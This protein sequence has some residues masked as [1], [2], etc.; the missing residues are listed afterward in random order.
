ML[1]FQAI[2]DGNCLYNA[3]AVSLITA[4]MQKKLNPLF[5]NKQRLAQ[6]HSLLKIF[7]N[8]GLIEVANNVTQ[9]SVTEG[10]NRLIERF[11]VGDEIDWADLQEQM[12]VGLREY[13]QDVMIND[14][15]MK[16]ALRAELTRSLNQYVDMAYNGEAGAMGEVLDLTAVVG[17]N[18]EG[19]TVI[20]EKI[21]EILQ[22][23]E[24]EG[25]DAKKAALNE[26]FFEGDAAGFSEYIQGENGIGNPAIFAGEVEIKVL[27]AK[28]G[29]VHKTYMQG[30][31][32]QD[33]ELTL[34]YYDA[35]KTREQARNIAKNALVFS[36]E[37]TPNHW[38]CLLEDTKANKAM[39][40]KHGM[41]LQSVEREKILAEHQSYEAHRASLDISVKEYCNMYHLT[42][43]QF[44]KNA[45]TFK[46]ASAKDDEDE[47]EVVAESAQKEKGPVTRSP[48]AA[49][50]SAQAPTDNDFKVGFLGATAIIAAF[51]FAVLL[52]VIKT[53]LFGGMVV[54]PA[55]ALFAFAATLGV[56]C[57]AGYALTNKVLVNRE[58]SEVLGK[59]PPKTAKSQATAKIDLLS[60]SP[61]LLVYQNTRAQQR[62]RETRE[63]NFDQTC[64]PS[65]Q[66]MH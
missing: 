12:A 16:P 64:V 39:I 26:W 37:K 34:N 53:A 20:E 5:R 41:H 21:Q 15:E 35:F 60:P 30:T 50:K 33:N 43:A 31:V 18:F 45:N 3:E 13:V 52:P 1:K 27:S 40:E 17:S 48:A 54:S 29:I 51:S 57:L 10:F 22:D 11:T 23:E 9:K 42:P 2:G 28:L 38:N 47:V 63:V 32:G 46:K 25:A 14:E 24:I 58:E 65:R 8:N 49:A 61:T 7:Q 66:K 19:M 6:F 55:V 44:K 59:I 36:F 4:F 56:S 62:K